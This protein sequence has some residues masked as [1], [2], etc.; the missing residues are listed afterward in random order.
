M[1]HKHHSSNYVIVLLDT[2]IL[3]IDF[4]SHFIVLSLYQ[5]F[6]CSQATI[7]K[8]TSIMRYIHIDIHVFLFACFCF[9]LFFS[10]RK[11]FYFS[12]YMAMNAKRSK[13]GFLHSW[14]SFYKLLIH[15]TLF[16]IY[17]LCT[18]CLLFLHVVICI[19]NVLRVF[20]SVYLIFPFCLFCI[21]VSKDALMLILEPSEVGTT[22]YH[23]LY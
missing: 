1:V 21:N 18:H 4:E 3:L 23:P 11:V 16:A 13:E 10:L 9:C 12:S 22:K 17:L 6:E 7:S 5:C 2:N 20:I 14:T 8:S 19:V 15:V